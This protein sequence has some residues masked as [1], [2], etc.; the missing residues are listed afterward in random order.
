MP[1]FRRGDRVPV[2][3]EPDPA[4]GSRRVRR[5]TVVDPVRVNHVAGT[6]QCVVAIS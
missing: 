3:G 4:N 1:S 2:F 6:C 5:G